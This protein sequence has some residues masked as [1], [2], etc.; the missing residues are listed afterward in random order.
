MLLQS[1]SGVLLGTGGVIL[2]SYVLAFLP[3]M[4]TYLPTSLMNSAALLVGAERAGDYTWAVTVTV[5]ATSLCVCAAV[6][7]FNKK[8][9]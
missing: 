9:L 3:K 1:Y 7:I 2:G 8:Q 4:A 6:P 5:I